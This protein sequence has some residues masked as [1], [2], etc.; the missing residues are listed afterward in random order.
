M[1]RVIDKTGRKLVLLAGAIAIVVGCFAAYI[2]AIQGSFI[3]DDDKYVTANPLLTAP[4]GLYRIWFSTDSP[5]QYFPLAYTTFRVEYQLWGLNPAGYH[6]VN[7]AIHSINALL[8]WLILRRLSIP[9]AWLAAAVFALH[10]VN[11]ES[12]AW[13]TERKNVLML[14]FSLLS[15]LCWVEFVFGGKSGRKA[16]SLYAG[17]L[18]FCALALLSKATACMLPAA[19]VLILWL[20]NSPITVKRWLQIVPYIAMGVCIGLLVMWWEKHHQGMGVNLGLSGTEKTLIAGRAL[21]FYLWK[22]V[23][24]VNLTFSYPRWNIDAHSV[25]QYGWPV[26]SAAVL[27]FAW[28]WRKRLGRGVVTAILF[29]PAMLFPMLGFFSLYTFVYTFV[30]DHYQYMASIGPIALVAAGAAMF[31]GRLG[32][33]ARFVIASA[34]GVLL[35][36][37]GIFTWQQCGAYKNSDTLWAD[38]LKKNPDSW[39]AHGQI[40]HSLYSQGKFDEAL[41]H[42]NRV[43]ELAADVKKMD[44]R[45]YTN[46][47]HN[48]GLI[49]AGKGEWENASEQFKME[50]EVNK[51]SALVH[52]LLANTLVKQGKIEEARLHYQEGLIIAIEQK[53]SKPAEELRRRLEAV[54]TILQENNNQPTVPG[55]KQ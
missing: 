5:S 33:N 25:W 41:S 3:W 35:L 8:I 28:F 37:L 17:S 54:K 40:G 50:L 20:K 47:Y 48:K 1:R 19:L 11:V 7:V 2:P 45:A 39:L 53:D 23:W 49:L 18:L 27:A 42:I 32:K 36:T 34:A 24:P 31:F 43:L 38:T 10:P 26:A 51:N 30:A 14:F 29:F 52:Y 12:V 6:T 16:I 46:A 55:A 9:W 13:I 22:L 15:I 21:W 44:P 4:D